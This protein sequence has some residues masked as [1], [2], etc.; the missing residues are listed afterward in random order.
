MNEITLSTWNAVTQSRDLTF[1]SLFFFAAT[2]LL[3]W[4]VWIAG[5]H[6]AQRLTAGL[7]AVAYVS[8]LVVGVV[9]LWRL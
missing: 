2:G 5:H 9:E 6:L 1:L 4:R 3:A 8:L 7:A